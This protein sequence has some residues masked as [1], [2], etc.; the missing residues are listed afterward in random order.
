MD[1]LHLIVDFQTSHRVW[2]TLKHTLTSSFNSRIIQFYDSFQNLDQ[3]DDLV[4]VFIQK[5]Y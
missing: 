1:V 4:I 2:H 5:I 3:G